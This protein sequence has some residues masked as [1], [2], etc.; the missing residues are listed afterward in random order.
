MRFLDDPHLLVVR[1]PP[2]PAR[3]G[4]HLNPPHSLWLKLMVKHRHKSISH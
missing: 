3:P 2:A 4:D 1:K